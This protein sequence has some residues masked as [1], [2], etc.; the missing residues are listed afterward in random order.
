M[1]HSLTPLIE[2]P[3]HACVTA[4]RGACAIQP[5]NTLPAMRAAVAASADMIEFDLRLT[6][7]GVPIL[8]H[9]PTL[10]RTTT[11]H[12]RPEDLTLEELRKGTARMPDGTPAPGVGV[13]TFEE[14]LREMRGKAGMNIQMYA[15][16]SGLQE[17]CRLYCRHAMFNLGYL[18]LARREDIDAVRRFHSAIDICY[19]PGW[20]ERTLPENLRLCRQLGCRFVQPVLE[21]TT[22]ETGELC[23]ELGLYAQVFYADTPERARQCRELA[24]GGFLTNRCHE[25][26]RAL[27]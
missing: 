7:D 15:P 8:L 16:P 18:T 12:G 4:H 25:L 24:G 1:F 5:E 6:R 3:E 10:D 19:T 22:A 9:D 14:V 20:A 23:R 21:H 11:L 2:T 26:V 13:P 17:I 27:P